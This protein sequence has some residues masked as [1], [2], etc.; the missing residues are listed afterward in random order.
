VPGRPLGNRC[1]LPALGWLRTGCR[2]WNLDSVTVG[3]GMSFFDSPDDEVRIEPN[4]R[5]VRARVGA[6]ENAAGPARK[7]ICLEPF[8]NGDGQLGLF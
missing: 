2:G 3:D 7:V 5:G 1:G 4:R 8:K 6:A